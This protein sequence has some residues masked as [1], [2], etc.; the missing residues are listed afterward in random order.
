MTIQGPYLSTASFHRHK[1]IYIFL[2]VENNQK[3]INISL[4]A[5]PISK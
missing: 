5:I 3:E 1:T 4:A 2:N